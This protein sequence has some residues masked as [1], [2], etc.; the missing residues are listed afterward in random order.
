MKIVFTGGGTGGH[1][2][3]IIAVAEAVRARAAAE[4]TLPPTLYYMAPEPYDAR[5]LFDNELIFKKTSA[6]KMRRYFSLQNFTDLFKTAWGVLGAMIEMYSIY[7]DV[8]FAKGGYVSFPAL[9]AARFYRIPVVIHES[10]SVPGRLNKWAGKFATRIAVSY[11]EA[12][13]FFPKDKVAYT[14]NPVRKGIEKAISNGAAEFFNLEQGVPT[15]LILGG[16]LGAQLINEVVLDSLPELVKT[17]QVIHQTGKKNFEEV[18]GTA[19]V[20]LK[21]NVYAARYKPLDYFDDLSMRMAAGLADVIVSRAGSTIFEIA[22]WE[23]PAIIIPITDS[24]GDHQRKNAFNYARTG[25]ASVI[26]EVNLTSHVLVSEINRLRENPA[27]RE[28]MKAAAQAFYR[29][30]AAAKIAQVII[31]IALQHEQ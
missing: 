24:N 7:P 14:G 2:Y 5:V 16:S 19:S 21:D 10:D 25:A 9:I 11:P 23:K 6:G 22:S 12:A 31:E 4:K 30:D 13:S 20:I 26:E 18:K 8:V 1:F 29:P 15:I 27:E 28:R 3:P 17:C